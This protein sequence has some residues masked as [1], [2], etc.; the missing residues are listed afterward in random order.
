MLESAVHL[1]IAQK[2]FDGAIAILDPH[3]QSWRGRTL[4][5][6][7]LKASERVTEF[8][9]LLQSELTNTLNALHKSIASIDSNDDPAWARPGDPEV[10]SEVLSHL[11][12]S[13]DS[14]PIAKAH[15]TYWPDLEGYPDFAAPM[16]RLSWLFGELA[17]LK[18]G[19]ADAN[20]GAYAQLARIL[21]HPNRT[22]EF[23]ERDERW[24][25]EQSD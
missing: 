11:D 7:I 24:L 4:L 10:L 20:R 19:L 2:D 8:E 16:A 12:S 13:F 1:R 15:H 25:W 3:Q 6:E 14:Q 5:A 21:D 9:A 17:S 22:Q 23:I 18:E